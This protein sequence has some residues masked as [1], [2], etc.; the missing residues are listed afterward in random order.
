MKALIVSIHII[1]AVLLVLIILLQQG[2]GGGLGGLFG[3]GGGGGM[4]DLLASPSSDVFLKKATITLAI[5]FF[6]TSLILAIRTAHETSRSLLERRTVPIP[7]STPI[8]TPIQSENVPAS[9]PD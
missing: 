4:D 2:K 3:G 1:A 7:T 8:P 6:L 9:E 5:V